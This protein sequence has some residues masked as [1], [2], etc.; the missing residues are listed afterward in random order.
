M[1]GTKAM[2]AKAMGAKA[3]DVH[4]QVRKDLGAI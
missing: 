1:M 3:G 4:R 2:G